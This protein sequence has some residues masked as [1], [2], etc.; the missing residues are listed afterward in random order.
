MMYYAYCFV[1]LTIFGALG[2]MYLVFALVKQKKLIYSMFIAE[3]I[4][5][6]AFN[7]SV[8]FS[9][10][11]QQIVKEFNKVNNVLNEL[12]LDS[13][14]ER[15]YFTEIF[16]YNGNRL[17]DVLTN[18]VS[19]HSFLP[20]SLYEFETLYSLEENDTLTLFNL[21]NLSLN[22][23][24]IM[25]YKYIMVDKEN[26]YG[27]D[28]L[29]KYYENEDF[30]V[31]ENVNYNSF[32]VYENYYD[33]EQVLSQRTEISD[34]LH[35]GDMLKDGVILENGNYKLN[36]KE[37]TYSNSKSKLF[38]YSYKTMLVEQNGKYVEKVDFNYNYS[39]SVYIYGEEINK[40]TKVYIE[41]DNNQAMCNS[42]YDGYLCEFDAGF[43]NIHFESDHALE[44]FDYIVLIEEDEKSF[45]YKDIEGKFSGDYISYLTQNRGVAKLI[46]GD[47]DVRECTQ[48]FCSL[49]NF[50]E[51]HILVEFVLKKHVEDNNDFYLLYVEGTIDEYNKDSDLEYAK[52]KSFDYDGS[53]INVK[54][55]RVSNNSNDQ[56]V[57]LPI[58]Y[59][60]EWETNNSDYKL[61]K[62]NGGFLGVVV[63]NG[64]EDVNVLITFAPTGVK[65]G[66]VGTCVGLCIYGVYIG[67]IC[68]KR[69]KENE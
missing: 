14:L 36:E 32:Y 48:D 9:T 57:V 22:S 67:F 41:K 49:Y 7:L 20:S 30:I 40:L 39:G 68:Y 45:L 66:F 31:Y 11:N 2:V 38:E 58:T 62:V 65:V 4:V 27:L 6:L 33:L 19:F 52:N 42:V 18:E 13:D 46:D 55:T 53:T 44:S 3:M 28:Y 12:E 69:K 64:I 25:D 37:F 63:K 43:D 47:G 60:D 23:K 15:V 34:F 35:F 8:P 16:K 54:Y 5:A 56:V 1:L 59:S 29:N 17:T 51:N 21:N 61:I 26:D 50:E 10:K 24:R